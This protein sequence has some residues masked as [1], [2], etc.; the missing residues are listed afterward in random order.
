MIVAYMRLSL[1]DGDVAAGSAEESQSIQSQRACIRQYCRQYCSEN[2]ALTNIEEIIDDGYSGTHFERPGIRKLLRLVEERQVDTIIV[3]DLSRFARNYLEAGHYLEYVFPAYGVRFISINDGYDSAMH[4]E[5]TAGL[6]IAVKN[7]INA[8][9]SKDISRKVKSALDLKKMNGEYVYGTAP[10]GYKKGMVKNTIVIDEPAAQV[11][12]R[13]FSMACEGYTITQIARALNDD[14]VTT[15]SVYLSKVRGKYKT[16]SFWTYESVRNILANRIYTGDT[17]PF[18]SHVV[19]IGSDR[20]K[21]LPEAEQIV[22]PQT[23]EAIISREMF[24]QAR[25][26]IKSNV[27]SPSQGKS[28]VLS[29]YLVCGCCNNK[30]T[31]G[32]PQNKTFLCAS[33]R[34]NTDSG[35]ADIRC[36]EAKLTDILIRAIRQQCMMMELHIKVTKSAIKAQKS[37]ADAIRT[38]MHQQKRLMEAAQAAKM[39][40]YES[41]V[42]GDCSKE[43]YLKKKS[44]LNTQEE[45]AKMQLTLLE[46]RQERLTASHASE[47]SLSHEENMVSRYMN[48]TELDDNLM[49]ELVKKIVVFPDGSVNIVWNFKD[50]TKETPQTSTLCD[51]K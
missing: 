38:Q 40:L 26:V 23:H 22:I 6:H 13:I 31:K 43:D 45:S 49:R 32:K 1:E 15:P 19:K 2:P 11:V 20:V 34:Y 24:Y 30:L 50:M 5:E 12:K 29:S 41:Y 7:L 42:A 47:S 37:E 8:M 27:K 9:Y 33:A 35:C 21:H 39:E 48:L 10:Y 4:N 17:V 3:R 44:E 36:S 16:R 18:K 51:C 25:T 46:E 28:S 14:G